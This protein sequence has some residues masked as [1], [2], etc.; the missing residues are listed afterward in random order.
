MTTPISTAGP[1]SGRRCWAA[2]GCARPE[3]TGATRS[4]RITNHRFC[5][6]RTE[7][8]LAVFEVEFAKVVLL[9]QLHQPTNPFD[10]ENVIG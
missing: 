6:A 2:L 4:H 8:L 10:V 3:P 5:T 1:A 7:P 9:H